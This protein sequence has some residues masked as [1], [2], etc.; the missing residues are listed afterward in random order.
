MKKL[1]RMESDIWRCNRFKKGSRMMVSI[2]SG[3]YR[4]DDRYSI[5]DNRSNDAYYFYDLNG[6]Q[7]YLIV[8]EF[9]DPDQTRKYIN[10]ARLAGNKQKVWGSLDGKKLMNILMAVAIVGGIAYGF[11][12]F[13]GIKL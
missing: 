9:V 5:P 7:P 13:G 10:H 3:L 6:T 2:A 1:I 4:T 12:A 8:P 11:I